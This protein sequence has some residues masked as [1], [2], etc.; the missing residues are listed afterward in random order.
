MMREQI[1]IHF[2]YIN[3]FKI[4]VENDK[5]FISSSRS[6]ADSFGNYARRVS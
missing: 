1:L 3:W 5:G 6:I 4:E 2:S